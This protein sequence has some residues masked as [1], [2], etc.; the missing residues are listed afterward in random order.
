MVAFGLIFQ[1]S[2]YASKPTDS[3]VA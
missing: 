3:L 1:E 2:R